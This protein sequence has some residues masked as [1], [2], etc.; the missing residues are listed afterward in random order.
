MNTGKPHCASR[1]ID[2]NVGLMKKHGYNAAVFLQLI[3]ESQI[4]RGS[5]QQLYDLGPDGELSKSTSPW[6]VFDSKEHII[7][8]CYGLFSLSS[9]KTILKDLE[10]KGVIIAGK[11][12]APRLGNRARCGYMLSNE[13]LNEINTI[14]NK[15]NK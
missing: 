6:V 9:L 1:E 4:N 14:T 10:S 15:E 5:D 12:V 7:W 13:T 3:C 8:E 11:V 2:L